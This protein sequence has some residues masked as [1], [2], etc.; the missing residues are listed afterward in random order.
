[1]CMYEY[2]DISLFADIHYICT[3][4]SYKFLRGKINIFNLLSIIRYLSHI[5]YK[6]NADVISATL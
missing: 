6:T 2:K 1:M 3:S 5:L 4:I